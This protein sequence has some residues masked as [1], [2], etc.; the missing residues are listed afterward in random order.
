[1]ISKIFSIILIIFISTTIA[2]DIRYLDTPNEPGTSF[3]PVFEGLKLHVRCYRNQTSANI[4]GPT[5]LLDA[6]L[7]FFSTA[8]ATILEPLLIEM[9][10][11][12]YS[13]ACLI[14]RYGY[15]FSDPAPFPFTA[16]EFV[17]RLHGSLQAAQVNPPYALTGW[18]WGSI[19][20]QIFAL[21]Y[22][23]EVVGL[24]TVDGTDP[25]W[26]FEGN[27]INVDILTAGME[28][29]IVM[30]QLDQLQDAA[31]NNRIQLGY[32][33]YN[34]AD[35]IKFPTNALKIAQQYFFTNNFLNTAIQELNI[36]VPSTVMLNDT[37]ASLNTATPYK[38][39]PMVVLYES[40]NGIEWE[41]RQVNMSNYSTNS[42][43][44][45]IATSHFIPWESPDAIISGLAK[46]STRIK[47]NPSTQ[48]I[49]S[50]SISC[51]INI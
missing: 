10:A 21:R 32:G 37:I 6:G 4:N 16:Q 47:N 15:G 2:I 23:S 30:K 11:L 8:W 22:P 41:Q 29:F 46:L 43:S 38:D 13:Q 14:D 17:R 19:D 9:P 28:N 26:G 24:F 20:M 12:N 50:P 35:S 44:F 51:P 25:I 31:V 27:Q 7:P 3:F 42:E 34:D 49:K 45:V 1:M 5:I 48:F 33:Y 40:L 18:S 36:M 39:L